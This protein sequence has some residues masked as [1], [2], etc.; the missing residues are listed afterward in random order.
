MIM[1]NLTKYKLKLIAGNRSIKDYQ[2]ISKEKLLNTLN[3]SMVL[4]QIAKIQNLS[5]N[6][7][8]QIT[9]MSNL[10]RNELEQ[11]SKMRRVKDYKNMSKEELVIALLKSEQSCAE[12][13]KVNQITQK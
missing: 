5:Q 3:E 11:I 12:L 8:K 10:S 4:K 1:K 13:Y 6:E 9:K 7:F 2:S